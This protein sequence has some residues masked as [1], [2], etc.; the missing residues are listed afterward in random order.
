[1]R[2]E[3]IKENEFERYYT[4]LEEDF[5]YDE[6]KSKEDE[7]KAFSNR[8]FKPYFIYDNN[9]MVGYMCYWEFKDFIFGEHFAVLK[10]KRNL[11]YGTIFFE[12]FLKKIK[13]T[14]VFEI[15]KPTD[16]QSK[17]RKKFYEQFN[18]SF[19]EYEYL[20]PS[21]HVDGNEVPMILVSYP[22]SLTKEEFKQVV[23]KVKAEVCN[24]SC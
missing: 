18:L 22:R 16:E 23:D 1:M 24:I 13:K 12:Y 14:L 4:L 11:G 19:N 21:Y 3:R 7:L 8:S 10:E 9:L 6:R 20:Q 5:C 17:K 2:M 15:E